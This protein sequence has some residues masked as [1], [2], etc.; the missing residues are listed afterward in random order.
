MAEVEQRQPQRT[1]MHEQER[2]QEAA[3]TAIAVEERVDGLELG[4]RERTVDQVRQP[5]VIVHE[6]LEGFQRDLHSWWRGRHE[7]CGLRAVAA[8][9]VLGA[10]KLPRRSLRST[11]PGHQL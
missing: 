7:A 4:M 11:H 2:D 9:P 5:A 3:D 6:L 1:A 10:A 8:D